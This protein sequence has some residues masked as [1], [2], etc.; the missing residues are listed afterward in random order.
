[1][2]DVERFRKL[3]DAVATCEREKARAEGA[4]GSALEELEQQ[5]GT[6]NLKKAEAAVVAKEQEAA[7]L[8]AEYNAALAQFEE[9]WGDALKQLQ[10]GSGNGN[11]RQG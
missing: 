1:M 9:E 5:V 10:G 3:K 7:Q 8:E 2:I 4:L 11:R 6:K